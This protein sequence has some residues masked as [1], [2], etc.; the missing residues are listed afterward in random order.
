MEY[1]AAYPVRQVPHRLR[2]EKKCREGP[3]IFLPARNYSN[4][5]WTGDISHETSSEFELSQARRLFSAGDVAFYVDFDSCDG[6][7]LRA[8]GHRPISHGQRGGEAR[9]FSASPGL[10]RSVFWRY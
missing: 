10:R 9:R 6:S 5:H 2:A 4:P 7:C 3:E 1:Y 8:V